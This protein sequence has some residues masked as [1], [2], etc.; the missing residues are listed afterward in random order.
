LVIHSKKETKEVDQ[1]LSEGPCGTE[2]RLI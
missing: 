1:E 2:P